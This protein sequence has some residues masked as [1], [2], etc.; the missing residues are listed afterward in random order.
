MLKVTFQLVVNLRNAKFVALRPLLVAWH[1]LLA[2]DGSS[3]SLPFSLTLTLSLDFPL[4][5]T[6]LMHR[7]MQACCCLREARLLHIFRRI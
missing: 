5:I 6:C 7:P 3:V 2:G 4:L 1:L